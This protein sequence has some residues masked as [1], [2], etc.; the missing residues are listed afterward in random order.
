M[1]LVGIVVLC[2]PVF[3]LIFRLFP[4]FEGLCS[5]SSASTVVFC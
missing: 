2:S 3:F 1:F 5:V 4:V